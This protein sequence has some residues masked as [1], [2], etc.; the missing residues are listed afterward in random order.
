MNGVIV[1]ASLNR[2]HRCAGL[3]VGA[4][5]GDALGAPF[6]F[7]DAGTYREEFSSPEHGGIGEM[8]GGGYFEW[9][10]GEF[11]D[12]TQMAL[13][14]ALSLLESGGF[15]PDVTW[16]F[17][18]NWA[19]TAKDIGNTTRRSLSY[20]NW[21][22][23]SHSN[24]ESTAANGALM[25]A[26]PLALLDNSRDELQA[27]V[28]QQGE[29]TH[30]HPAARWGAWLG[31]AMMHSAIH[32]NNPFA[33]LDEELELLPKD[34]AKKF[35]PLLTPDWEPTADRMNNGSVWGC[36][37]DA[38]WAVRTSKS[39]EEAVVNAINLGDDADTVGCVA[40]ALAG[41]IYGIQA[42]P[43]RW[44]TYINGVVD[45][46]HGPELFDN[47]RLNEIGRDLANL[48]AFPQVDDESPVGPVEVEDRLFAANRS[49]A[50]QAPQGWAI[51]SLCL[52]GDR[53]KNHKFRREIYLIDQDGDANPSLG[54]AVSDAVKSI[55][56]FLDE[57]RTVLV[58]C[59]GGRSR[60]GLILKAWKM[61]KESWSG[62]DGEQLAHNWLA[63][64]WNL[65]QNTHFQHFLR[66]D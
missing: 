46:P 52:V 34:V 36:L 42:V 1:M 13:S 24:P 62:P 16:N 57:G 11:T 64:K 33:T 15:D 8:I 50:T 6:E 47:S 39:F 14:L 40:G 22:D 29:M 23:V 48:G 58:H 35:K 21:R 63:Q 43:S 54:L 59:H 2:S 66:G 20:E 25:R 7:R 31:V 53:F 17:W 3:I 44:T 65:Y 12:D 10:P 37:A 55:D 4:A 32:G 19:F 30:P 45:T 27:I 56:A 9:L 41:A 51:I 26:F 61:K 49:G 5:V 38:V 18:R 28:L 60:T